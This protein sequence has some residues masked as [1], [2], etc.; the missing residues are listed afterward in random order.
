MRY[1][2]NF[3]VKKGAWSKVRGLKSKSNL[4]YAGVTT[5][6]VQNVQRVGSHRLLVLS[7]SMPK[8]VFFHFQF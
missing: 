7:L 5:P 4:A 8:V 2:G 6:R 1:F 3:W